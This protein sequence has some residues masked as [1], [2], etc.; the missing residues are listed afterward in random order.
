MWLITG[1]WK[2][3]M[4]ERYSFSASSAGLRLDKAVAGEIEGLSR[5]RVQ[6]LIEGGFILVNGV[7]SRASYHLAE[8]DVVEVTVPEPEGPKLTAQKIPLSIIFEDGDIIVVDKPAGISVHP[9]PGHPDATLVNAV[10]GYNPE[11]SGGDAGRPGIV[12]RLD[13]DTS[14]LIIIARNPKAHLY[15]ASQFKNRQVKKTYIALVHGSLSPASGFIDAP[16]GRDRSHRKRMAVTTPENGRE[17]RTGYRVLEYFRG[18]TL[19]EAMPETGRTHQIRVHMAAIGHPI[20]GDSTYGP[21]SD[22]ISRQFL[23]AHNILFRLPSTGEEMKLSAPLPEDL[24][25]VLER[26]QS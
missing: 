7:I 18:Y 9:G 13:K 2:V 20:A 16:I 12:H 15:I 6:K 8:G 25:K 11:I 3:M 23:H 24:E 4:E 26:L 10:L 19:L 17:A 14:G 1:T 5:S 21:G 22:M